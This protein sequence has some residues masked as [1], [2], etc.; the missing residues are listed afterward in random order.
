[1]NASTSSPLAAIRAAYAARRYETARRM[2][3]R[4]RAD[5]LPDTPESLVLECDIF[6]Y[7]GDVEAAK[8]ALRRFSE[9]ADES[10]LDFLLAR[11]S[12]MRMLF[13]YDVYQRS[14][15]AAAGMGYESYAQGLRDRISGDIRKAVRTL[16]GHPAP[17]QV[18]RLAD[19]LD[20]A[21]LWDEAKALRKRFEP[22]PGATEDASPATGVVR[23][24]LL[25]PDGSPASA[26]TVVLGLAVEMKEKDPATYDEPEMH[27]EPV[28]GEVR[29]LETVADAEG[30]YVFDAVPVGRHAFLAARLDEDA[31]DI[32]TRFFRIGVEVAADT[33]T[34]VDAMLDEWR[35]ARPEPFPDRLPDLLLDDGVPYRK[36]HVERLRN[37]F[38]YDFPRQPY[39][40]RVAR[41]PSKDA[42]L[43]L[44]DPRAARRANGSP[45]G[46]ENGA[47]RFA[48]FQTLAD[49]Q[50]LCLPELPARSDRLI[51]LYETVGHCAT[52]GTDI[53]SVCELSSA[54]QGGF[55]S[56]AITPDADGRTAVVDTGRAAFRIAWGEAR[57]DDG[58]AP[59]VSVRAADGVWRGRGRFVLPQGVSVA[60]RR[61]TILGQGPLAARLRIEFA[62]SDG[63]PFRLDLAF[64]QGEEALLARETPPPDLEG[65][66]DF[67]LPEFSGGRGYAYWGAENGSPHWRTLDAADR[68]LA[69]LQESVMW[70]RATC[71]FGYAMTPD[72]LDEK[73]YIAVFTL[74]RG[75]WIDRKFE[76]L[77]H[78]PIDGNR[79]L[80]WPYP[81]MIGSTVSMITV[82]TSAAGDA[83][84]HF[85]FF[86]G[87]RQWGLLASSFAANDGPDKELARSHHKFGSPRLD[88]FAR[89]NL[90]VQD[91]A[92]RPRVV[93]RR[94]E[95]RALR[96]KRFDPAFAESWKR[97]CSG[98][99]HGP[100]TGLRFAVDGDPL[101]AWRK[102]LELVGVARIR[103]RM[104]LLGRDHS[105]MYSPVGA[106]PITAWAEDY[107]LIAA[108]GCFTAQEERLVRRF[109]LLMGHMYCEK[110]FMNWGFGARNA[111]FEA[112][113][114]DVVGTVGLVF[115]GE[116]DADAMAD[117][118]TERTRVA[119]DA[120]CTPGSGKWYENPAC[121]YLQALKCRI[122]LLYHLWRD[123]RLDPA[124]IER[125]PD[126][127]RWGILLLTPAFPTSDEAM[128]RPL[129]D[130][131][132]RAEP[133]SRRLPPIGDHAGLGTAVP[134]HFALMGQVLRESDPVLADQLLWAYRTG[135]SVGLGFGNLPLLFA[136]LDAS[137]L[138][139]VSPPQP[140]AS[141][142]L[143][144]F[145]AVFRG[146][147]DTPQEFYLLF[148]QGPGGYRY[149]NTEG[150]LLLFADGKPLVYD[151]GEAGETW[152]HT[153]LAFH[154][155][156]SPLA[157]GHVERFASLPEADF[158]QG[159]H[160]K[161]L[162]AKDPVFLSDACDDFLVQVA[163]DRFNEPNPADSRSVC[164]VK[165]A[166]YVVLHDELRLPAG[167]KTH[168]NVQAVSDE[169]AV[170]GPGDYRF[171][172]RY[173]TDLQVLLPDQLFDEEE[174]RQDAIL[175]F[176][177]APTFTMRHLRLA[178]DSPK[179][180]AA[181]LRPLV[182]GAAPLSAEA[183]RDAGG[184][185]VGVHVKGD[186][187]DDRLFF[188]RSELDW[189]D[190]ARGGV[191]FQGSYGLF[192]GRKDGTTFVDLD[193]RKERTEP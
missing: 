74:R 111:N 68:E 93:A 28:I 50:V 116:P 139:P 151:G 138:E 115:A 180:I 31:F 137:D 51:G 170:A 178:G 21:S 162:T 186:G 23:G 96:A 79:E 113:R 92:E 41:T 49:G 47:P 167:V 163:F 22:A 27:Y 153:T 148:K 114:V 67:S 132:Y 53:A 166:G 164:W 146:R 122:N 193:A 161:A 191:R 135:G 86:D 36:V 48:P 125:L 17:E 72:G 181:V 34:V 38:D 83:A 131:A 65:A 112:D 2:L 26:C 29:G 85:A 149:H 60:S 98:K 102:K 1:M 157:P 54:A 13:T 136:S 119:L 158:C 24:T 141:R 77:S 128:T 140:L 126:L 19:A 4:A 143:E 130:A 192:L 42:R 156:Q 91:A 171:K 32:A 71:D 121:Y 61:T 172:G 82:R 88:D 150:S 174:I 145:G 187:I 103:A 182:A 63:S 56:L 101:V 25:L 40:F 118:A 142:R 144:G 185:I 97:I 188:S 89:W 173:G 87:E 81:E 189:D 175:Q 165:D 117:H 14:S 11:V 6:R 124:S 127:M 147:F 52:L 84:F 108:S 176:H 90:D 37:P 3:L 10:S 177:G 184:R 129:D 43:V 73:D 18:A 35:S 134:E 152:R 76:R 99:V 190:T 62:F 44:L 58:I 55:P 75:E 8:A 59:I 7:L 169:H 20:A 39:R 183:L 9:I 123:G 179:G 57:G 154:D 12:V 110:D 105:D 80:D 33:A 106:R 109:L 70:W 15:E 120:Y 160:P 155:S 100:A 30:R 78:G 16:P 95:L 107:D 133:A 46:P 69:R 104:T 168:W 45:G 64:L 66:F 5:G 94:A 159:V